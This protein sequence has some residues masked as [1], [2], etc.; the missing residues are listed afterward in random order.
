MKL[1]G[2]DKNREKA[3]IRD[4][5]ICRDCGN[6]WEKGKR[7][8]DC[9]HINGLC[10]KKSRRYDKN[11]NDLITLCHKCHYNRHDRSEKLNGSKR[12][13]KRDL[14]IKSMREDRY[15]FREIGEKYSLTKQRAHQ[16]Y[17]ELS[18]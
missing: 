3:R 9:H 16:I 11:I 7:R 5:H 17:K 15:S 2:R 12:N 1:Q 4:K 18:P 6:K 13:I 14:E 10:G 8:L